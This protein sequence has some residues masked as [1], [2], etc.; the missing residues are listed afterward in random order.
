MKNVIYRNCVL[1]LAAVSLVNGAAYYTFE[2]GSDGNGAIGSAPT[3]SGWVTDS[4]GSSNGT[5]TSVNG[6]PRYGDSVSPLA[7]GN[8]A[9][10][11]GQKQNSVDFGND[12]DFQWSENA[13]K[14]VEFF[15]RRDGNGPDGSTTEFIMSKGYTSSGGWQM[16]FNRSA[17]SIRFQIQGETIE[18]SS[19]FTDSLWHHVAVTHAADSAHYD[20]Y[21][22]Y[23]LAGSLDGFGSG[24]VTSAAFSV[25][26]GY[27]WQD[28]RVFSGAID[29]FRITDSVLSTNEFIPEPATIALFGLGGILIRRRKK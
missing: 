10:E 1:L 2:E 15:V 16:T 7:S 20:L 13:S 12:A 22:D 26:K 21:V 28:Q 11:F 27:G 29:E 25:G 9:L 18:S 8:L 5:V 24:S 3:T 23:E 14:T 17:G 19:V 6:Y 4:Y